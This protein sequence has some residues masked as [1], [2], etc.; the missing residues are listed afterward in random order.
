MRLTE[1]WCQLGLLLGTFIEAMVSA[2]I[3]IE[4]VRYEEVEVH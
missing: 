2:C 3:Y 4:R 1:L